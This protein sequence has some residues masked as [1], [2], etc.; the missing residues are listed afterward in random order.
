MNLSIADIQIYQ[1][2]TV[3]KNLDMYY[4]RV[5]V[6]W[7]VGWDAGLTETYIW[8]LKMLHSPDQTRPDLTRLDW[9]RPDKTR[10]DQTK[11]DQTRPELSPKLKCTLNDISRCCI[12]LQCTAHCG[13]K[14]RCCITMRYTKPHSDMKRWAQF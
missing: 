14:E 9:T 5:V 11:P 6:G 1:F 10:P 2:L 3:Q 12:T 13:D 7:L 4:I 8:P